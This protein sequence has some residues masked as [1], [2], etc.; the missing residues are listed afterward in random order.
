[1]FVQDLS[2][3]YHHFNIN[4]VGSYCWMIAYQYKVSY[5]I[6]GNLN[7]VVPKTNLLEIKPDEL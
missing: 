3:D 6:L 1:M 4:S 7:T 5:E 2:V